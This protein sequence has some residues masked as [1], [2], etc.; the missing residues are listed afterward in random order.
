VGAH[1]QQALGL[2]C[3]VAGDEEDGRVVGLE[4]CRGQRWTD[5]GWQMEGGAVRCHGSGIGRGRRRMG[6]YVITRTRTLGRTVSN[7]S[8]T[9]KM[10]GHGIR[11]E[12]E[13]WATGPGSYAGAPFHIYIMSYGVV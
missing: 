1:R 2:S 6:R 9:C 11:L 7:I 8:I 10:K 4:G 5:S 3:E 12:L 13:R